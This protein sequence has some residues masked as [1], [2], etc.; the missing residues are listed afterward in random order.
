MLA[1][2]DAPTELIPAVTGPPPRRR[3]PGRW[4]AAGT[5]VLL[6]GAGAA[7][8][9]TRDR[10]DAGPAPEPVATTASAA[11]ERR[12]LS[13]TRA[14]PGRIG[15]GAARPVEGHKDATVTWLPPAGSTV[16]RGRQLYRADDRPV[17]LFYGGLPLYRSIGGPGLIGRD[18]RIIA[19]NL[20]ALGYRAGRQPGAGDWVRPAGP[21]TPLVR[22]RKG[23][24][25]LTTGLVAAIK[26]WQ[27]DNDLPVTGAVAVGDV[28]V[29]PGAVR[30]ESVAVQPGAPARGPLLS[31]TATRKVISVAADPV[32]AGA[33][34]RGAKVTVDLP[35]ERTVRGRVAAVGRT[36]VAADAAVGGE[37]PKL[38]V[39][40]VLTDPAGIAKVDSADV[41]VNFPGRTAKGVLAVPIEALV[42]LSEGGY[43]VQTAAGLVAV[44]TGMF[45][46]GWVEITGTGLSE[47]T[48]V[49][50]TS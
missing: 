36:V 4:L 35:D 41:E 20:G 3:R 13:T 9:A 46:E 49:T 11:I 31:V 27:R 25:V 40:V 38:T 15:F 1:E 8:L 33:V 24:G 43:A 34:E 18:V 12:D 22:V 5:A 50:V 29:Q 21:R 16:K 6:T 39:T 47:G 2:P 17:P 42:A 37:T 19:D 23:E 26:A 44:T 30:V 45:A 32:E 48:A 10:A 28:E 7:F 14:L